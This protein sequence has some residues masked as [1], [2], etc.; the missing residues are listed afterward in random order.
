MTDVKS[1]VMTFPTLH[2]YQSV[3]IQRKTGI[4]EGGEEETY[5]Q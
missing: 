3:S 5:K 4:E 1:A 2:K